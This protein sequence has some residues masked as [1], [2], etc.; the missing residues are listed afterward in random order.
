[1]EIVNT[2]KPVLPDWVKLYNEYN[3]AHYRPGKN[4]TAEEWNTLFLANVR[5]SNYNAD[6]LELLIKTYL[7]ETYLTQETFDTQYTALLNKHTALEQELLTSKELAQS[8]ALDA[9][10]AQRVAQEALDLVMSD[11]V[12]TQVLVNGEPVVSFNADTKADVRYV[13]Q[14]IAALIGSA[15]ETLNTLEE[16]A[17]AFADNADMLEALQ[18]TID[19]ATHTTIRRWEE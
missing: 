8:A 4:I 12:R 11:D 18:N 15:P 2:P 13:D 19:N 9:Q 3:P 16:V 6:T 5:Q 10:D 7:P 14:Q 17:K 1:M